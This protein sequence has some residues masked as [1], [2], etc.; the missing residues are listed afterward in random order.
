[1]IPGGIPTPQTFNGSY[2]TGTCVARTASQPFVP[3]GPHCWLGTESRENPYW[4][5]MTLEGTYANSKYN[6]GEIE[7]T[8]RLS[9]GLRFQNSFTWSKNLVSAGE[10]EYNNQNVGEA[11]FA[12][13][14]TDPGRDY[15]LAVFDALYKWDFNLIY[16]LPKAGS[17]K[18][19][20][21][22]LANGWWTSTI[23]DV[24]SGYP[25]SPTIATNRDR[26]QSGG[27][28]VGT[29]QLDLLPGYNIKDLTSG[30]VSVGC[31]SGLQ[32]YSGRHASRK[33]GPLV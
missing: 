29:D 24:Q 7:L 11:P 30:T 18:G 6:A 13:D 21:G 12:S 25:F 10:G 23:I 17:L 32:R 27:S 19:L 20:L 33:C 26:S 1:M 9:K 14:P 16:N 4:G 31:G 15:A 5:T 2:Y 22:A 8:K 3:N 28:G